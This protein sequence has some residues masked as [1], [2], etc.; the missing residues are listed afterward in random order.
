MLLLAGWRGR[1]LLVTGGVLDEAGNLG[2]GPYR[3]FVSGELCGV[4]SLACAKLSLEA[5]FSAASSN[6]IPQPS[7]R[8]LE[9]TKG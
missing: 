6:P 5:D 8:S 9:K 2:L 1:Q 7:V 3:D 4:V